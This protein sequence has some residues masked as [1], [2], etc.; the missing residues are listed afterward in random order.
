M[1]R[2][3]TDIRKISLISEKGTDP[4]VWSPKP[5]MTAGQ[6]LRMYG[7]VPILPMEPDQGPGIS[8]WLLLA[9]AASALGLIVAL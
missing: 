7:D 8:G 6:K 1:R 9:V 4:N 5:P 2:P 3:R